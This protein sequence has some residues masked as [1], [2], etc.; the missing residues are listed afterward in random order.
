MNIRKNNQS[1]TFS[2][3][4]LMVSLTF[5][6]T[7]CKKD[8][9]QIEPV[10]PPSIEVKANADKKTGMKI[11]SIIEANDTNPLLHTSFKLKKENK[12]LFDIV[13]LF[14]ANINYDEKAGR[15]YAHLNE[16]V[17][18]LLENRMKYIKPL[19]DRGTKVVLSILGNHDRS[20]VANLSD[21]NAKSF[22]KE[23]ATVC[24]T[25]QLDGIMLD[26]EYSNYQ[27]PPPA[28]FVS[29]SNKAAARLFYEIKKAM[30][31]RI[32]IVYAYS[33]TNDFSGSNALV[34]AEAGEYIDYVVNDYFANVGLERFPGVP[35][36][37]YGTDSEEFARG[38][39]LNN[40]ESIKSNGNGTH[41]IFA[42][43]Q[44]R[45]NFNDQL[46]QLQLMTKSLFNDELVYDE[47][48]H[49]KDW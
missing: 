46:H 9:V 18:H 33:R 19:Q 3:C 35:N 5:A 43:D 41:M 25:Y 37:H 45:G 39:F 24:E 7:G 17:K 26:D 30:P 21:K 42:L 28:G 27:Y 6:L 12:P 47:I 44:T 36:T 11:I 22:A 20:G 31:D 23:L 49:R 1:L 2:R 16:N 10:D 48:V 8:L 32:N 13:V 29:P 34:E 38:Y 40:Y 14:S 15:V 4:C